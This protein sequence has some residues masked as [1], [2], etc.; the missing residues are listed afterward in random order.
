MRKR[1][2]VAVALSVLLAASAYAQKTDFLELVKTGTP[3]SI[4]AALN[5]GAD[6]KAQ[7]KNGDTALMC[8]AVDNQNPKVITTLL[9][10]RADIKARDNDGTTVLMDAAAYNKNAELIP[11]LLNAGADINDRDKNGATPLMA[12]A[13]HNQNPDVISALLK[14]GAEV[15]AK[16]NKGGSFPPTEGYPRSLEFGGSENHT[17]KGVRHDDRR[18]RATPARCRATAI[19]AGGGTFGLW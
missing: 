17:E 1:I 3:Q 5:K 2:V 15:N 12:A 18:L 13:R 6:L 16:N 8:A 7:D 4:Q 11:L 10:A 14:A 9:K 19:A